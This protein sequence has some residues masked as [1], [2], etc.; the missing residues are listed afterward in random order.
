M[1]ISHTYSSITVAE[2]MEFYLNLDT[3]CQLKPVYQY[4]MSYFILILLMDVIS[5]DFQQNKI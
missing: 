2:L 4:T 5:G 1:L 3:M